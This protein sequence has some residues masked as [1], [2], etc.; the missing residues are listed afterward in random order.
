MRR[1]SHWRFMQVPRMG[2]DAAG[3]PMVAAN[4]STT[5]LYALDWDT[6]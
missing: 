3:R 4:R 5:A 2:L 1:L 6:P